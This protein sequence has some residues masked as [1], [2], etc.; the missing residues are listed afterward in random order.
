MYAEVQ[1]TVGFVIDLYI[2]I[3]PVVGVM[4]LQLARKR[5]LGVAAVFL[6]PIGFVNSAQIRIGC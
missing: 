2:L 6:T 3:L 1:S 4:R 5:K